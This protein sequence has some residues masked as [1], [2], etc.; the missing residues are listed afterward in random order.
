M[1]MPNR[2]VELTVCNPRGA[3]AGDSENSVVRLLDRNNPTHRRDAEHAELFCV[4]IEVRLG[5][6]CASAGNH[7]VYG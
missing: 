3:P 7:G 1:D 5:G 2:K 6:L 4:F